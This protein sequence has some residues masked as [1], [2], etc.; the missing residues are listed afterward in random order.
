MKKPQLRVKEYPHSLTARFVIEGL[1]INGKRKRLFFRTKAEADI[2][3]ARIKKKR[4]REGEDALM[5]PDGL[6]I[7]AR[8]CDALLAPFSKTLLDA[9]TFYLAHLQ[10]LNRSISI[11]N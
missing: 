1:R 10:D 7:M 9:T 5:I 6:R 4:T 8:D 11:P 3:L 2:E